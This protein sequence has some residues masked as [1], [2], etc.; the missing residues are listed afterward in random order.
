MP[1]VPQVFSPTL[2][3]SGQ[4]AGLHLSRAVEGHA[5]GRPG[6]GSHRAE[7]LTFPGWRLEPMDQW[8]SP[9]LPAETTGWWSSPETGGR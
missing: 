9:G 5:P 2:W 1:H 3:Q 4:H 6:N 8:V 7:G